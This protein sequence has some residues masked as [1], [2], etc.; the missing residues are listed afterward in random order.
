MGPKNPDPN[1]VYLQSPYP[2]TFLWT[3]LGQN[4]GQKSQTQ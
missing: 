4:Q 1:A 2:P 3:T